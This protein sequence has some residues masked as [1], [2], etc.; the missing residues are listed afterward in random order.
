MKNIFHH[1]MDHLE[2]SDHTKELH[3]VELKSAN[4]N[5]CKKICPSLIIHMYMKFFC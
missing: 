2:G 3:L 1:T 4:S 5:I